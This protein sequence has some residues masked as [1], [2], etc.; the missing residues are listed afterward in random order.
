MRLGNLIM[1]QSLQ[2]PWWPAELCIPAASHIVKLCP[3]II[4]AATYSKVAWSS[5]RQVLVLFFGDT[6]FDL[7]DVCSG[8]VSYVALS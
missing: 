1:A 3:P 4:K 2:H 6:S 7:I 8:R 5:S